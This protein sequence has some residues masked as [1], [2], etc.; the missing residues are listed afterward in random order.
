MHVECEAVIGA[1]KSDSRKRREGTRS[2]SGAISKV[3]RELYASDLIEIVIMPRFGT[4]ANV[5]P[6]TADAPRAASAAHPLAASSPNLTRGAR[7]EGWGECLSG[8]A[9]TYPAPAALDQKSFRP[10][11]SGGLRP[12]SKRIPQN[13]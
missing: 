13:V 8:S 4:G 6:L 12:S 7:G 5:S 2:R 1:G 9:V 11:G 10:G 3:M